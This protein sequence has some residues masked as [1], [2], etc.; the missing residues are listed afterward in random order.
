MN[1]PA[2]FAALALAGT[3][4]LAACGS[5]AAPPAQTAAAPAIPPGG[6]DARFTIQNRSSTNVAEFYYRP[7]GGSEWGTDRFGQRLLNRGLTMSFRAQG[8]GRHDLRIVWANGRESRLDNVN[9]CE[10]PLVVA[11]NDRLFVP[12]AGGQAAPPAAPAPA[13][14]PRRGQ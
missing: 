13:A 12:T 5:P 7:A 2:L 3:G 8:A 14:R 1:R 6:C 11:D 9:L 10:T 4:L